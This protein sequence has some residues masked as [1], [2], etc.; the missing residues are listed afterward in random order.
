M[1]FLQRGV[2]FGVE[3]SVLHSVGVLMTD[4]VYTHDRVGWHYHENAYFTFLLCGGML[5]GSRRQVYHCGAGTLLFHHWQEPHY[6][7]KYPLPTRGFHLELDALWFG[8][9]ELAVDSFSGSHE[10]RNP[11]VRNLFSKIYVESKLGAGAVGL[12]I[13]AL[14]MEVFGGLGNIAPVVLDRHWS[15]V[16][17]DLLHDR[18]MEQVSLAELSAVTGLHPVHI[19]RSFPQYFH[20]TFGEYVRQCRVERAAVL[21]ADPGQSLA[22]V[23]YSCG[24]SDQSHFTRSFR[25]VHGITPSQYRG[26]LGVIFEG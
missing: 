15:K 14:L 19:S 1:D 5:E 21:M 17:R 22:G 23:A 10:F 13:E 20:M 6:N 24:F 12:S 2:Y 11:V 25:K 4:T 8:K 26:L 18:C 7:I 16:V 9:H 3:T